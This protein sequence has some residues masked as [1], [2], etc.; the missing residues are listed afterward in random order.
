MSLAAAFQEI[1]DSLPDDWTDLELDLRIADEIA[2]RRRR[3][4]PGRRQ[5]PAL[6]APRLALAAA[7]RPPLRPC[8]VG[9]RRP[10]GARAARRLRHRRASSR[11]ARC[12]RAAFRS[13]PG[14][15]AR[16][17]CATSC[18]R[19]TRSSARSSGPAQRNRSSSGARISAAAPG[20][21]SALTWRGEAA[22]DHDRL[23]GV[24]RARQ[25]GGRRHRV[26]DGDHARVQLAPAAVGAP[27]PVVERRQA[28]GADRDVELAVAPGAPE[29][30]GDED[31]G[32]RARSARCRRARSSRAAPSGSSGSSTTTSVLGR[33]WTRRCPALAQTKPWRVRTIS[34]PRSARTQLGRLVE[35]RLHVARVLAVGGGQLE[36]PRARLDV[37][38]GGAC[39]PGPSR[40]PCGRPRRCR[41]RAASAA[42]G[43]QRAEVGA[44]VDL[45]QPAERERL[46][47]A[48]S[49]VAEHGAACGRP[50]RASAPERREV[51]RACRCRARGAGSAATRQAAP[52]VRGA[53]AVALEAALAE[54]RARSTSG[55]HEQQR[56]G[57]GAVAVGDD[58]HR[59]R[60]PAGAEQRA[61]GRARRAPG[62]RR[63][64]AGRGRTP[65]RARAR[66]RRAP[67]RSGRTRAGRRAPRAPAAAASSA[68]D[69]SLVTTATASSAGA[70]R[71][72]RRARRRP[73]PARGGGAAAL[74]ERLAEPR[75]GELEALDR[76]DRERVRRR[77]AHRAQRARRARAWRARQLAALVGLGH[78]DVAHA[79]RRTPA[80]GSSA[81]IPSSS[82]PVVARRRRPASA[83]S[84]RPTPGRRRSA[85]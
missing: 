47:R 66:C 83:G 75:L 33:R 84:A 45:G 29:A 70:A 80:T 51:G 15:A 77:R 14:G 32:P 71:A 24:L 5:R 16:S 7:R 2:L 48:P 63:G 55:G 49:E 67:R 21:S 64:R 53:R 54:A 76:E 20:P 17:R 30:V 69:A 41:R 25:V 60:R 68:T 82:A 37:A 8:R 26:G 72:A 81:T 61:Q 28:G 31:G 79:A 35:D 1:V 13:S 56:V 9:L 39:G 38:R 3:R 42:A 46:D 11:C 78:R 85:P 40:P 57:A 12:A 58:R 36:R 52:G 74:A 4:L 50:R 22:H 23:A 34:T 18:A 59:G 6:L 27:A 44:G 43:D 62:S 73:S 10:H 19:S 65:R